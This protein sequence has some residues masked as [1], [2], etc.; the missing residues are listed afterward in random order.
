MLRIAF[1]LLTTIQSIA[2]PGA[3]S[4][5]QDEI[6]DALAHAEAL[7]YG[8]R[9]NESITLLSR[10]DDT[11]KAQPG[12]VE[13]KTKTKLRLALAY[14][15]LNDT[16]RAKSLLMELYALDSDFT[17]DAAQYSP[18]VMTVVAEAKAEQTKVQ[19]FTAQTDA[20]SYL[21]REKTT[22]FLN[23]VRSLKSKCSALAALEPVAADSFYKTGV[24]AYRR[25]EFANAQSSFEATL[26]LVP[27]H[28][29]ALQYM[30]LI[31]SKQQLS[32]DRLLLQW[33][34]NF[35]ARQLTAAAVD[36]RQIMA[37]NSGR[38][39]ATVNHV[40]DEYR[41]ALKGLVDKWNQTCP[42]GDMAAMNAIR[43]QITEM[44]PDPAFGQDIRAQMVVCPEPKPVIAAAPELKTAATS[45]A[46][47]PK[48]DAPT[49]MPSPITGCFEMQSQLALTRLKT[50]VD[51]T[52][53]LE[54]RNY[55]KTN[56]NVIVRVKARISETGDV[57]VLGT[58]EGSPFL[59]G[60]VRTAVS[61][62]KF[63]PI[64]DNN[65]VRCVDTE[66]P[67][68]IKLSQ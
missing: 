1:V 46:S 24:A 29:L 58:S 18:K 60:A 35:D 59:N 27:E 61:Q 42:S 5:R 14:I 52:L 28:E 40:N 57:T 30:D 2:A 48:P 11:L 4:A 64:R 19:C 43:A 26:A 33:Q 3:Q 6:K 10:V 16:A 53:T 56:P 65:G 34:R 25:N 49:A 55:L 63:S 36:Y 44:V 31:Q 17:F 50:R 32:Q 9:F 66:I 45:V 51:P 37:A 67:I 41:K 39:T 7:Y 21:E 22:E 12:R 47:G 15:G 20:R 54:I 23:L 68:A 38:A 8:A 13:D 62:W